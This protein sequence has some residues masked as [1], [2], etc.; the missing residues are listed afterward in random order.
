MSALYSK[1]QEPV[2]FRDCYD[3]VGSKK[4]FKGGGVDVKIEDVYVY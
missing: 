4:P 2:L 1:T 3:F